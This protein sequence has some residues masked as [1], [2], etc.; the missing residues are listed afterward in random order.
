MAVLARLAAMAMLVF[1]AGCASERYVTDAR[2]PEVAIDEM[3]RLT[4]RNSPVSPEELPEVL[5]K[6]GYTRHDTINIHV[7]AEIDDFRVARR[8]VGILTRNGFTRAI[9]V[10]D[11]KSSSQVGRTAEERRRDQRRNLHERKIK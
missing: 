11:R 9:L 5:R 6:S 10:S 2:H 8:T 4:F 7:P 3:G 1:A